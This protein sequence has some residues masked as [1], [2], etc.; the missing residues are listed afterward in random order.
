VKRASRTIFLAAGILLLLIIGVQAACAQG[1][2]PLFTDDPG[3]PGDQHWEINV[4]WTFEHNADQTVQGV[5]LLD[6]NFGVGDRLQ[7]KYQVPW[8]V[9]QE[10]DRKA[11]TGLGNGLAGVKWRFYDA[12]DQEWKISTYPQIGFVNPGSHSDRRDLADGGTSLILP[13]EFQRDFGICSLNVECGHVF[14]PGADEGEWL[15]GV[16]L[17]RELRHG[18]ELIAEVYDEASGGF[19][20]SELIVNAGM[21]LD[22]S[23]RETLLLAVGRDLRNTLGPRSNLLSYLGMQT[24]Y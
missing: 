8:V 14:H 16:A 6:L 11:R 19:G 12:G 3:T 1:G 2:P 13:V 21:R 15:G 20:Q 24:R 5:P 7:L 10:N 17:G 4:A 9:L 23:R 22:L 18:L